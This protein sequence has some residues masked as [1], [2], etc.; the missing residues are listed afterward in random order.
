MVLLFVIEPKL[1]DASMKAVTV[2][3]LFFVSGPEAHNS[4]IVQGS[5]AT[6]QFMGSAA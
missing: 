1:S 2:S 5:A 6:A 3:Q 4:L